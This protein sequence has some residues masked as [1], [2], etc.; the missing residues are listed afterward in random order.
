MEVSNLVKKLARLHWM[1]QHTSKYVAEWQGNEAPYNLYWAF[2]GKP[3]PENKLIISKNRSL[4][5]KCVDI[6]LLDDGDMAF[7]VTLNTP[8]SFYTQ[9]VCKDARLLAFYT[10]EVWKANLLRKIKVTK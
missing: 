8:E 1:P 5:D 6:C 7:N 4:W 9:V 3:S 10:P 2:C